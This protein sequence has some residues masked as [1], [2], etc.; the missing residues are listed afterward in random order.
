MEIVKFMTARND[1]GVVSTHKVQGRTAFP[2]RSWGNPQPQSGDTWEVEVE[3]MNDAKTVVFLRPVR[4]ISTLQEEID[5]QRTLREAKEREAAVY[6]AHVATM[7]QSVL[8]FPD[9]IIF[10]G[11]NDAIGKSLGKTTYCIAV[12]DGRLNHLPLFSELIEGYGFPFSKGY[13]PAISVA[14]DAK[15]AVRRLRVQNKEYRPSFLLV[16]GL[17]A[18]PVYNKLSSLSPKEGILGYEAVSA[19]S[20]EVLDLF[21]AMPLPPTVANRWNAYLT[22]EQQ[23]ILAFP[24]RDVQIVKKNDTNW[25]HP[26]R[27]ADPGSVVYPDGIVHWSMPDW[28]VF[29]DAH[30]KEEIRSQSN[31]YS[32]RGETITGDRWTSS[33]TTIKHTVVSGFRVKIERHANGGNG[34]ITA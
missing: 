25:H 3:G 21:A 12:Q 33:W 34:E 24:V 19:E 28:V 16:R 2:C 20:V 32:A 8:A 15:G 31:S 5:A 11:L 9:I 7:S 10:H 27:P 17:R 1:R 26:Y 18:K 6:A 22:K 30:T 29:G 14:A 13:G 4:R 23:E